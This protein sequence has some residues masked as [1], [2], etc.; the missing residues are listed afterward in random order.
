MDKAERYLS[1]SIL[2]FI[3]FLSLAVL[4][5]YKGLSML[6]Y[7][8][9]ICLAVVFL[10]F[11]SSLRAM[12]QR[13]L[14]DVLGSLAYKAELRVSPKTSKKPTQETPILAPRSSESKPTEQES[15]LYQVTYQKLP[16]PVPPPP[17]PNQEDH[18]EDQPELSCPRCGQK[19]HP[20]AAF[21][22]R[23]GLKLH[24]PDASS[25]VENESM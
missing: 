10:F 14:F 3:L 8:S 12:G 2:S 11:M 20:R 5:N 13:D 6:L 17:P 21:C 7:G 1:L 4:S 15:T 22:G 23:C 25:N 9:F 16:L 19:L 18:Q 24:E